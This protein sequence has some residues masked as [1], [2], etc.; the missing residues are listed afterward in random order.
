MVLESC[1]CGL[2]VFGCWGSKD[3]RKQ[4]NTFTVTVLGDSILL[5]MVD[6]RAA[7]PRFREG[8]EKPQR[9]VGQRG[10]GDHV[11]TRRL[12]AGPKMN[13]CTN[14]LWLCSLKMSKVLSIT[15][16]GRQLLHVLP[17]KVVPSIDPP[18]TEASP[19]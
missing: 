16:V 2:N 18:P 3:S 19:T 14:R 12:R 10:T 1:H 7:V 8:I 17:R 15:M 13:S 11:R 4:L 5:P 6:R 9:S